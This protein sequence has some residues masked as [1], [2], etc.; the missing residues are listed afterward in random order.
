MIFQLSVNIIKF[1]SKMKFLIFNLCILLFTKTLYANICP[2][3]PGFL[4]RFYIIPETL[5]HWTY[6]NCKNNKDNFLQIVCNIN[7]DER[8]LEYYTKDIIYIGESIDEESAR[9]VCAN[10]SIDNFLRY[11]LLNYNQE[12]A[13]KTGKLLLKC[14]NTFKYYYAIPDN[15]EWKITNEIKLQECLPE[16]QNLSL[17]DISR[18]DTDL[19]K[20]HSAFTEI[21]DT[22]INKKDYCSIDSST[23]YLKTNEYICIKEERLYILREKY[24]LDI[25][26][27]PSYLDKDFYKDVCEKEENIK[28]QPEIDEEHKMQRIHKNLPENDR[29]RAWNINSMFCVY[30]AILSTGN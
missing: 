5:E 12:E 7:N 16:S 9:A 19:I 11:G 17:C 25:D 14:N 8:P 3:L 10:N 13:Y 4:S 26:K 27:L 1:Y 6:L 18:P 24:M 2:L 30:I 22:G 20:L 15:F 23:E 21:K 28:P 29:P